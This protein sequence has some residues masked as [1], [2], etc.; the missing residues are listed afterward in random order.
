M[1]PKPVKPTPRFGL[2]LAPLTSAFSNL[3]KNDIKETLVK[4]VLGFNAPRVLTAR[5]PKEGWDTFRSEI[6]NTGVTAAGTYALAPF[7]NMILSKYALGLT[8]K[9]AKALQSQTHFDQLLKSASKPLVEKLKLARM[10][11]ALGFMLP[12][13]ALFYANPFFRNWWTLKKEKTSNFDA[14]IG[15]DNS[16]NKD[17][18]TENLKQQLGKQI[19]TVWKVLGVGVALAAASVGLVGF[20]IKNPA[21]LKGFRNFL[22]DRFDNWSLSGEG[23]N[24]V[25]G[26][27]ATLVFWSAP[28]YVGWVHAA[29]TKS[30]RREWWL[31]FAN[32]TAWFFGAPWLTGK[33]VAPINKVLKDHKIN[34]PVEDAKTEFS[35]APKYEVLAGLKKKIPSKAYEALVA[36]KTN[37]YVAGLLFSIVML[38]LTPQLLNRYITK[39]QYENRKKE[40]EAQHLTTHPAPPKPEPFWQDM[41][42]PPPSVAAGWNPWT[43]QARAPWGAYPYQQPESF[44]PMSA[45]PMPQYYVGY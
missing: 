15:L 26:G 36:A 5:S 8:E 2:S 35:T 34:I 25:R 45:W 10:G 6:L 33:L 44:A 40:L 20:L 4:D 11:T 19:G 38:G 43:A 41:I 30:E 16:N 22:V 14:L 23:L 3:E 7:T 21:K 32:S 12:F 31:K 28:A 42:K 18:P 39:R 1:I 37:N 27:A 9:E 29:R 17:K 13:A 24:Q